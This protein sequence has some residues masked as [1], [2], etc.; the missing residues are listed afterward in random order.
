DEQDGPPL[1][2]RV[3]AGGILMAASFGFF[4]LAGCFAIGILILLNPSSL[5]GKPPPSAPALSAEEMTLLVALYAFA[6]LSVLAAAVL[7]LL[8]LTGLVRILYGKAGSSG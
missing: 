5:N 8:G 1:G 4:L 2:P 6:G 3:W 7:F